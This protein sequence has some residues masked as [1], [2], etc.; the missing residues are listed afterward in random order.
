MKEREG[1]AEMSQWI[2]RNGMFDSLSA[3]LREKEN[4]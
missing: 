3:C 2:H 4:R 1:R